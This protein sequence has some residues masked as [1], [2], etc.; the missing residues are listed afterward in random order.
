MFNLYESAATA[1]TDEYSTI[2]YT[3]SLH[4]K[5]SML[6]ADDTI[7]KYFFETNNIQILEEIIL[8]MV[9]RG[10]HYVCVYGLFAS[11][12]TKN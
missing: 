12:S 2:I 9:S 11:I 1:T 10:D 3:I 5:F 7:F 8:S 4:E 6:S